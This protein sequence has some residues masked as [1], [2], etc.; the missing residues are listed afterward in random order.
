MTVF[1]SILEGL[2][3]LKTSKDSNIERVQSCIAQAAK[4]QFDPTVKIMQLEMLTL[5]LDFAS[6]LYHQSPDATAQK[7]RLLQQRLDECEEWNNVKADFQ[8]PVKKQPSNARTVSEETSTIIRPGGEGE[9]EFDF[10][11][12]SFMTKVELRSLVYV[13]QIQRYY[14][15]LANLVY[16]FTFSGL[17]NMH[18]P[19]AQGRR[20]TEFWLEGVK[21]LDTCE[22]YSDGLIMALHVINNVPGDSS[23]A[24]IPYGPSVSLSTAIRQRSWRIEAQA[25]LSILLGLLAASHCQWGKVKRFMSKLDTLITP[26]TQPTIGLLST[27]L[28][29]VYHQ[30]TGNLQAALNIFLD[31]RFDLPQ[32]SSGVK[33]GQREIALLAGLNRLWIMQHPSCRNDE[34]THELIEQLQPFCTNHWNIDLRTAWHNVVAALETDPPQQLNQQ[35]Q[36]IQAAMSGSKVTNNILGAAV[37]LCIMRSRFFENVIGEQALKSARAASKQAQR[38][39]NMLWQSVADGMLAQSYEVQGHRDESSQEWEKAT[40]EAKD[41]F[42]GSW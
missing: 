27:Y 1:A 5:L 6:S 37:T 8:I 9:G 11:V 28:T 20:S 19:S 13:L 35:K 40:K 38:S 14:G 39:G 12:M 33:A 24:G 10:V 42:T 23:T 41:A 3:L 34:Q 15:P 21:I 29:G 25:Y 7:L 32:T 18:K 2:A 31:R 26:T 17:A 22:Y 30:G 16:R 4:F 36:H